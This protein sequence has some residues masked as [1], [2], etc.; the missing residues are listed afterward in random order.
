MP[1]RIRPAALNNRRIVSTLK[2]RLLLTS[3][4]ISC[5]FVASMTKLTTTVFLQRQ[6]RMLRQRWRRNQLQQSTARHDNGWMLALTCFVSHTRSDD[7]LHDLEC[8]GHDADSFWPHMTKLT[9][10]C[11]EK[12]STPSYPPLR[13]GCSGRG[14]ARCLKA[15]NATLMKCKS[16]HCGRVCFLNVRLKDMFYNTLQVQEKVHPTQ[17]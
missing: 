10:S 16:G 5:V 7:L 13:K 11:E 17:L 15:F 14:F 2:P 6:D 3:C 9:V 12:A 8:G 4:L 1:V